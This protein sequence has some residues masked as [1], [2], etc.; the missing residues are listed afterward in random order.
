MLSAPTE[1]EGLPV[2]GLPSFSDDRSFGQRDLQN[3]RPGPNRRS[4]WIQHEHLAEPSNV[5]VDLVMEGTTTWNQAGRCSEGSLCG[6]S[7]S[8]FIGIKTR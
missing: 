6:E 3:G 2:G 5:G 4:F 1:H 8:T 7:S